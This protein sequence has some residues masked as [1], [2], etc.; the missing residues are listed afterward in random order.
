MGYLVSSLHSAIQDRK[1]VPSTKKSTPSTTFAETAEESRSIARHH[2]ELRQI[3]FRHRTYSRQSRRE[4]SNEDVQVLFAV[5]SGITCV[6]YL[7]WRSEVL[8]GLAAVSMLTIGLLCGAVVY[9]YTKGMITG[10]K[11]SL[12]LLFAIAAS[13]FSIVLITFALSPITAP[14][15]PKQL[16]GIAETGGFDGLMS[17][18]NMRVA[19]WMLG[20]V[21]GVFFIFLLQIQIVLSLAHYLA[22]TYYIASA[23]SSSTALFFVEKTELQGRLW[24]NVLVISTFSVIAYVFVN[25][26]PYA[27]YFQYFGL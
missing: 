13:L 12:Y 6:L 8:V 23:R 3:K 2:E 5:G 25:G 14:N 10:V 19:S 11:W 17:S 27:W 22:V 1:Q 18:M 7:I 16:E 15:L 21:A 4:Q 9:S 26:Y 20:H 24:R